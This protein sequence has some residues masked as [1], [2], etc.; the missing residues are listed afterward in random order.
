MDAL[1]VASPSGQT[2]ITFSNI[3]QTYTHLQ[4]RAIYAATTGTLNDT[5]WQFNSDT[6]TG[7]YYNLHQLRTDGSTVTG[8]AFNGN[9]G[10]YS[11]PAPY[12]SSTTFFSTALVD[13][14]D[15]TSSS[16]TTNKAKTI[17]S[18]SGYEAN[19]SGYIFVRSSLWAPATSSG[20]TTISIATQSGTFVAG[21]SF[22]LYGIK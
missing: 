3:P 12:S 9:A 19:G 13:I 20:V 6:T 16:S 14:L 17:R 4:V 15:Y 11:L 2:S 10:G 8:Q 1:G 7:N 22:A 18:L 21:T 5:F